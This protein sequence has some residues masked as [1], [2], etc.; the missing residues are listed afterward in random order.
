MWLKV[1]LPEGRLSEGIGSDTTWAERYK[2]LILCLMII[3]SVIIR[4]LLAAANSS[5]PSIIM[6]EALYFSISHSLVDSGKVLLRGQPV[7]YEYILYPLIIAPFHD[8]PAAVNIFRGI[9]FFNA[10]AISL[11][12]IPAFL[13]TKKLTGSAA[14]GLFIAAFVLCMPD[15]IM[16][17]HIMSESVVY[18]LTLVLFYFF[19]LS[20]E[21]KRPKLAVLCGLLTFLLHITKPGLIVIGVVIAAVFIFL[22]V[23]GRN[24]E[25]LMQAVYT[26]GTFVVLFVIYKLI[27]HFGLGV[28]PYA[29]GYYD[30]QL[31][32]ISWENILNAMNGALVYALYVP[33]AFMVL[34]L[35]LP[36]S[37]VRRMEPSRRA[38]ILGVFV[39]LV[40]HICVIIWTIY[41]GEMTDD[42]FV[43]R[44]HTRYLA[45]YF[46]VFLAFLLTD[47]MLKAKARPGLIAAFA[48]LASGWLLL[49]DRAIVSGDIFSVDTQLLSAF[50][51]QSPLNG[52]VWML[53]IWITATVYFLYRIKSGG[54]KKRDIKAF[55]ALVII[56]M[57]ITNISGYNFD[58]HNKNI[59][60]ADDAREARVLANSDAIYL[61]AAGQLFWEKSMAIDM[62]YR[63][64]AD[65][66]VYEDAV[67]GT[68]ISGIMHAFISEKLDY[69]LSASQIDPAA[70]VIVNSDLMSRMVVDATASLEYTSN[71]TYAV[72]T[73]KAGRGWIHSGLYGFNNGWV[74]NGSGFYLYD[75]DVIS[76]SDVYLQLYARSGEGNS[77]LVLSY[78]EQAQTINLTD[79]LTWVGA[80]FTVQDYTQ[81]VNITFLNIGSNIYIETYLVEGVYQ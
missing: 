73:P 22:A 14:K 74:Q 15:L 8:L 17:R 79:T 70:S 62:A 50:M 45:M 31:P 26:V 65:I 51:T 66:V 39:A 11:A 18:P 58:S 44:I 59:T 20:T 47:D 68:G 28:N 61:T 32:Q 34:P 75:T 64:S 7:I 30:H 76:C 29:A 72:I 69:S 6:D 77:V 67:K 60:V 55:S 78:G 36:L 42:P 63:G 48:A 37:Q 53:L 27:L 49:A 3:V 10:V 43:T 19:L 40:L 16:V 46:P 25:R 35:L 1:R 4:Y 24:R 71:N 2:G 23:S 56:V 80:Y 52:R 38:F 13:I 12:S 9:Q 81:P 41:I 21:D 33:A 57:L 54:L 5:A